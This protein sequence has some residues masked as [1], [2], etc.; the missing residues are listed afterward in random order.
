M[1]SVGSYLKREREARKV[2]VAELAQTT[3]IP[4]RVLR[5][6]EDDEHDQLPADVFVRG[7]LRAY[8]RALGLDEEHVLARYG[9]AEESEPPP[10]LPAVYAPE[11]G[12]RFGIAIALFILLILFTLALSIVLRPRHRDAPVQLSLREAPCAAPLTSPMRS[13][14]AASTTATSTASSRS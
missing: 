4:I 9:K 6:I 10:S 14:C 8:A 2:S 5:Q 12:R 7:F 13:C 11:S 1:G 3:R